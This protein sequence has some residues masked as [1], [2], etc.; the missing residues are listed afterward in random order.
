[1]TGQ[2]LARSL[3]SAS[4]SEGDAGALSEGL[5]AASKTV[6]ALWDFQKTSRKI[7]DLQPWLC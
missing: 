2:N 4:A 1:M 3:P 7:H 6:W 5:A